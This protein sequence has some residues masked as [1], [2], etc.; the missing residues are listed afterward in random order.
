MEQFKDIDWN[1]VHERLTH[2][3]VR[4]FNASRFATDERVLESFGDGFQ[5][6]AQEVI[7]ELLDQRVKWKPAAHGPATTKSVSAFLS[8]VLRNDFIDRVRAKRLTGQL[9]IEKVTE[10][11]AVELIADPADSTPAVDQVLAHREVFRG[12]RKRLED[13]FKERPDDELQMYVM[14][15]FDGDR[16]VPY[17]PRDAA[18]ELGMDV[19]QVYL[20]KDKLERRLNRIFK[21]ELEAA[22]AAEHERTYEQEAR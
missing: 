14:L 3:A 12:R 15:Q 17:T 4:L 5:D 8:A 11:A 2:T 19:K 6:L 20:L 21:E 16:Y 7:F 9:S 13:D 10:G 22:R 1:E 18:K